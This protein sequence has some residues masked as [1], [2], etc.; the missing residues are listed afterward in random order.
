MRVS[1]LLSLPLTSL[2]IR[3]LSHPASLML[4]PYNMGVYRKHPYLV[5]SKPPSP[6]LLDVMPFLG[7]SPPVWA[8]PNYSLLGSWWACRI[9][10]RNTYSAVL[11]ASRTE[12]GEAAGPMPMYILAST[13]GQETLHETLMDAQPMPRT[14]LDDLWISQLGPSAHSANRPSRPIQGPA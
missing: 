11:G 8:G 13:C 6:H 9:V 1:A 2:C 4:P 10:G 12:G 7:S 5:P 14:L 3:D